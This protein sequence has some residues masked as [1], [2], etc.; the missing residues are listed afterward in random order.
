MLEES[1]I[2]NETLLAAINRLYENR[3]VYI[4]TMKRS[5]Q[6]NSIDTIIDLIE[7]VAR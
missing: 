3:E 2:T 4:E 1:E 5:S 6:Q 7:S